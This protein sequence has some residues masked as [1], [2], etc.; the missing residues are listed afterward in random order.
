MWNT[1]HQNQNRAQFLLYSLVGVLF[2]LFFVFWGLFLMKNT[3]IR[4]IPIFAYIDEFVI[5]M[6]KTRHLVTFFPESIRIFL[7]IENTQHQNKNLA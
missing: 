7:I 3:G 4:I 1:Q 2:W 6:S 5:M